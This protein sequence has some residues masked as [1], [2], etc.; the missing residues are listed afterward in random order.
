VDIGGIASVAL[1][2]AQLAFTAA[3]NA[4]LLGKADWMKYVDAGLAVAVKA[5]EIINNIKA[6]S[7]DYDNMTADEVRTLLMPEGWQAL[8]L[9]AAQELGEQPA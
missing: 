6:G 1:S 3:K 7:V 4:G 8:E 5:T 9:I 2:M